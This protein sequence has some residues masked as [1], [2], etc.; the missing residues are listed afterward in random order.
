MRLLLP[1]LLLPL[2]PLLPQ[3][4][5]ALSTTT[6]EIIVTAGK[7]PVAAA[8]SPQRVTVIDSATIARSTDLG[9]LLNEQAGIV[10]N[11]AY[12][13][14]GK[15]RSIFLRNAAN[16][17]TL[18]L[19]DG[20]PLVDPSSLG[21]AVD[22]RLLS[23]EGLQRIEILR[24]GRSLLYGSDAVAGVINL[25]T[26]GEKQ[27]ID[28]FRLHLRAA[29]QR[30]AT[31]EG[32]IGISGSTEKFDY[33]LGYDY[34]TTDGISE[35]REPVGSSAN[36]ARDGADRRTLTAGLT[37]RP[38]SRLT[39]RPAL[40]RATF[41]GDY[42]GGSFQDADNS[43]SNQLWLP[44]LAVDYRHDA[45]SLG[46][47]YNYAITDR[48]FDDAAFGE[49]AFLGRAQQGDIFGA[50]RFSERLSLTGGVQLRHERLEMIDELTATNVAPYLL[51]NARL[52]EVVLAEAGLRYNRHSVF[53]G[54][55]NWSVA[56][57]TALRSGW[58]LRLSAATAFQS[59]T[60]DQLG[61]PFGANPEL[62]PQVSTSVGAGT[63]VQSESGN[64]RAGLTLFQRH[65][66]ELITFDFT[67]GYQNQN[68]LRDRGVEVEASA[69]LSDRF[70]INGNVTYVKGRLTEADGMGGTTETDD[71][72]RRP[73]TTGFLGLTYTA[74]TPFTARLTA[75]YTGERPDVFFNADFERFETLLDPYLIV[76]AYAEY[77][78]CPDR[79]LTVFG[80]VRN[81]T[82]TDFTEVTGFGVLGIT[83]RLGVLWTH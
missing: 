38:S 8:E 62:E 79:S 9:Q 71:F 31:F 58:T 37:Y 16:Q 43:Y 2:T 82:N 23:L 7:F 52:A 75:A 4:A 57:G 5:P 47:T 68:E 26:T 29:A 77:Q 60:L 41:N 45:L 39:I 12:S 10:V 61:G 83:P 32:R 53:G 1:L 50:Y 49:S 11:G 20:Q 13:N 33:R 67:A 70:L 42:D 65:I 44:S 63:Q 19:I 18:I 17:Y 22:L 80:E 30:Y 15:D 14:F 74:T 28:P 56:M 21:G 78:F 36:F 46:G 27:K 72:F 51:L 73:R 6:E 64:L 25:V 35:A 24:G 48:V 34:F 40:R 54:Q 3:E 69:R 76:N 66:E 55:P 59:P 81:L